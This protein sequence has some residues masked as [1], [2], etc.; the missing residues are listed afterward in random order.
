MLVA[1]KRDTFGKEYRFPALQ[2]IMSGE[3]ISTLIYNLIAN[4]K[5]KFLISQQIFGIFQYI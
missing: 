4:N 3:K 1:I 2:S 5:R